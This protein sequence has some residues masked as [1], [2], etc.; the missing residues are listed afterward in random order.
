MQCS[1]W[2]KLTAENGGHG[3]RICREYNTTGMQPHFLCPVHLEGSGGLVPF[4]LLFTY[5]SI[6]AILVSGNVF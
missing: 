1:G 6:P 4:V 2:R 3:A 5:V